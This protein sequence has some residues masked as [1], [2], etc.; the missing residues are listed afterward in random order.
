MARD[1]KEKGMST[2]QVGGEGGTTKKEKERTG[3]DTQTHKKR[4]T[5]GNVKPKANVFKK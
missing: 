4:Q 2:E 1:K 3:S 5:M